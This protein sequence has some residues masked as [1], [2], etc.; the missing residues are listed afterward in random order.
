MCRPGRGARALVPPA[1]RGPGGR[2]QHRHRARLSERRKAERGG[3]AGADAAMRLFGVEQDGSAVRPPS[4]I[5]AALWALQG[6]EE[7]RQARL[8]VG[9]EPLPWA[10]LGRGLQRRQLRPQVCGQ[11][12]HR[13]VDPVGSQCRRQVVERSLGVTRPVACADAPQAARPGRHPLPRIPRNED[14]GSRAEPPTSPRTEGW[15][16]GEGC[17]PGPW[18][19]KGL[20]GKGGPSDADIGVSLRRRRRGTMLY[21]AK[22]DWLMMRQVRQALCVLGLVHSVLLAARRVAFVA[23]S[24]KYSGGGRG[25]SFGLPRPGSHK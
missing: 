22:R 12:P 24:L 20:T 3:K 7:A 9:M 14:A 4:S 17:G 16:K 1:L 13:L 8:E 23:L 10:E 11:R 18:A 5:D 6:R 15:G 2:C 25:A 19:S 21:E